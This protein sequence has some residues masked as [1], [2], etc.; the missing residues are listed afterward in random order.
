MNLPEGQTILGRIQEILAKRH[1]RFVFESCH[2][3]ELLPGQIPCQ[4]MGLTMNT[5]YGQGRATATTYNTCRPDPLR[6]KP[7]SNKGYTL[8]ARTSKRKGLAEKESL[9]TPG[10]GSYEVIN[11]GKKAVKPNAKPFSQTSCRFNETIGTAADVAGVGTYN[12]VDQRC[13]HV[14]W[15]CDTM[16]R[17][18]NLPPVDQKSSIPINTDKLPTTLECKRYQRKLAYLNLFF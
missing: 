11:V 9:L 7:T 14:S 5:L 3:R 4:R 13:H 8:G 1:S 10:P 15:Q 12:L 16:K 18:V 2:E 6:T 17:P